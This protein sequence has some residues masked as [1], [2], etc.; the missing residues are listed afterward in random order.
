MLPMCV[1]YAVTGHYA[2]IA[3]HAVL[4]GAYGQVGVRAP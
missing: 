4:I 2:A 3:R 1:S